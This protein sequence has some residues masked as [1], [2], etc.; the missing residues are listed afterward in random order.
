M[1]C[2]LHGCFSSKFSL[3]PDS[4]LTH[5]DNDQLAYA[6]A[7]YISCN[8]AFPFQQA[9]QSCVTQKQ[10]RPTTYF[11]PSSTSSVLI[12]FH[13]VEVTA[14]STWMIPLHILPS[15][16]V[17]IANQL[18]VFRFFKPPQ[19]YKHILPMLHISLE[20]SNRK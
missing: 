19:C 1:L 8:A 11:S 10:N 3:F 13:N 4:I 16:T 18:E 7:K 20:Y 5:S 12:L 14:S 17:S 15:G 2:T 9:L 6:G